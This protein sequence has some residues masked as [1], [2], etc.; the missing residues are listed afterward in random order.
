MQSSEEAGLKT[1]ALCRGSNSGYQAVNLAYILGAR[2][3]I[4]IGYDMHGKGTHFFGKHPAP[5][6]NNT[7]YESFI[8][9]FRAMNPKFYGV[10]VINCTRRT[11]IPEEVFKRMELK[12]ALALP[13][14]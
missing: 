5:L 1:G 11:A 2:R 13:R 14:R 9:A 12:S 4:L 8:A 6:T 10:E 3:I 7:D